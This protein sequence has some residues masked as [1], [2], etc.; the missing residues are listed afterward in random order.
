MSACSPPGS[1][2]CCTR[3]PAPASHSNS[4]YQS[5]SVH[6]IEYIEVKKNV[7][8]C[9]KFCIRFSFTILSSKKQALFFLQVPPSQLLEHGV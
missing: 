1:P 7:L 5:T 9:F 3:L 8:M 6:Y 4:Q 2:N